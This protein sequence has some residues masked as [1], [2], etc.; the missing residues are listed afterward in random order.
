MHDAFDR[1]LKVTCLSRFDPVVS[2]RTRLEIMSCPES[3]RTGQ[4]KLV[5]FS[6]LLPIYIDEF[7]CSYFRIGDQKI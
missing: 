6:S 5:L 1:K 7:P 3:G 4:T 2:C